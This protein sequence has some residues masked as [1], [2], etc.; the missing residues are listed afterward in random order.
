MDSRRQ[1]RIV[2]ALLGLH[3]GDSLGAGFEFQK[4]QQIATR[5]PDGCGPRHVVGGGLFHWEAGQATDDTYMTRAVLLASRDVSSNGH[6][7]N[8]PDVAAIAG[9]YFL[10]WFN[11]N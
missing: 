4:H 11:G 9:S 10:D 3:A 5:F 8:N 2:G 7:R 6:C 1:S